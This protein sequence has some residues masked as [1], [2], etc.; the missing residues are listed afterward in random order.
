MRAA[1]VS[2][3]R[4]LRGLGPDFPATRFVCVFICAPRGFTRLRRMDLLL[5]PWVEK[6]G[7]CGES[8]ESGIG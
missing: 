4:G 2:V 1:D 5:P 6:N 7:I 3:L 8:Q